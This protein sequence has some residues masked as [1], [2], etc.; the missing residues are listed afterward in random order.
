MILGQKWPFGTGKSLRPFAAFTMTLV[1]QGDLDFLQRFL[2]VLTAEKNN[3]M[4]PNEGKAGHFE[5]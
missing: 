3:L 2:Q 4:L 5:R 1:V